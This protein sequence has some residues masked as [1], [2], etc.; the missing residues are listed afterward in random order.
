[1]QTKPDAQAKLKERL[2]QL[3]RG[4]LLVEKDASDES[5]IFQCIAAKDLNGLKELIKSGNFENETSFG[6][7]I[8]RVTACIGSVEIMDFLCNHPKIKN[9]KQDRFETFLIAAYE[10]RLDM[11]QYFIQHGMNDK[12]RVKCSSGTTALIEA[13]KNG[14]FEMVKF[15]IN[16]QSDVNAT[17]DSRKTAL[18][19]AVMNSHIDIALYLIP[20]MK[21]LN[22][23]EKNGFSVLIFT[24]FVGAEPDLASNSLV[25]RKAISK[26]SFSED[27]ADKENQILRDMKHRRALIKSRTELNFSEMCSNEK[28]YSI[29]EQEIQRSHAFLK[30]AQLLIQCKV[31]VNYIDEYGR[32]ALIYATINNQ[33]EIVELLLKNDATKLID[34]VGKDSATAL[35]RAIV[36][37][38]FNIVRLLLDHGADIN[39]ESKNKVGLHPFLNIPAHYNSE[40]YQLLIER[41]ADVNFLNETRPFLIGMIR[42]NE[43]KIALLMVQN[44]IDI[45]ETC[46]SGETPLQIACDYSEQNL[47]S[48]K[49]SDSAQNQLRLVEDLINAL[50]TRG[51]QVNTR[52]AS[53]ASPLH[54]CAMLGLRTAVNNLLI[55]GADATAKDNFNQEPII[56]AICNG[57][58]EI[59]KFLYEKRSKQLDEVRLLLYAAQNNQIEICQYLLSRKID[60]NGVG[61]LDISKDSKIQTLITHPLSAAAASGN[62]VLVQLFI[63]AGASV[64]VAGNDGHNP[65][66]M[67]VIQGDNES[68]K[69]LIEALLVETK[70]SSINLMEV[71]RKIQHAVNYAITYEKI[72]QFLLLTKGLFDLFPESRNQ[73]MVE[74]FFAA[75][76]ANSKNILKYFFESKE[77]NETFILNLNVAIIRA[78]ENN[79]DKLFRNLFEISKFD[80][81][82][83]IEGLSLLKLAVLKD[84][85]T[86]VEEILKLKADPHFLGSDQQSALQFALMNKK[87]K[88]GIL[89]LEKRILSGLSEFFIKN[90]KVEDRK[91]FRNLLKLFCE[92][93]CAD[94]KPYCEMADKTEGLRLFVFDKYHY[95]SFSVLIEVFKTVYGLEQ[96]HSL[97]REDLELHLLAVKYGSDSAEVKLAKDTQ[98]LTSGLLLEST[99]NEFQRNAY[100]QSVEESIGYINVLIEKIRVEIKICYDF[101]S[102]EAG[103]EK[104]GTDVWV[105][106]SNKYEKMN[107]DVDNLA[108]K[109]LSAEEDIIKYKE[110]YIVLAC[111]FEE[112]IKAMLKLKDWEGAQKEK[113]AFDTDIQLKAWLMDARSHIVSFNDFSE[114]L[115]K[116]HEDLQADQKRNQQMRETYLKSNKNKKPKA[117][118]EMQAQRSQLSDKTHLQKKLNKAS[119]SEVSRNQRMSDL[120]NKKARQVA[121][122]QKRQLELKLEKDRKRDFDTEETSDLTVTSYQ[123]YS[124]RAALKPKPYTLNIAGGFYLQLGLKDEMAVVA[125]IT[126]FCKNLGTIEYNKRFQIMTAAKNAFLG[127]G[128]RMMEIILQE[129]GVPNFTVEEAAKFRNFLYHAKSELFELWSLDDVQKMICDLCFYLDGCLRKNEANGEVSAVQ[130]K[131]SACFKTMMELSVFEY[132]LDICVREWE[133]NQN[134]EIYY[135]QAGDIPEILLDHARKFTLGRS[136]AFAAEIRKLSPNHYEARKTLYDLY[137]LPYVEYEQLI[138]L[139]KIARHVKSNPFVPNVALLD[140]MKFRKPLGPAE[141]TLQSAPVLAASTQD[142]MPLTVASSSTSVP[143]VSSAVSGPQVTAVTPM[144]NVHQ[145]LQSAENSRLRPVS[146]LGD[147]KAVDRKKADKQKV[148]G[149]KS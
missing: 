104:F 140:G 121:F 91:L 30:V 138:E 98:A 35:N 42:R 127:L 76:E 24:T 130:I 125:M 45:D 83:E 107:T 77:F 9:R 102:S 99:I 143:P 23:T 1:M 105:R 84:N 92:K 110:D 10:G 36:D 60:V 114:T 144:F 55:A 78:L 74:M 2:K 17:N 65:L 111:Q 117:S 124:S 48:Q 96:S 108:E 80:P 94:F 40:L 63:N 54:I 136:G 4:K 142:A 5:P 118:S 100:G 86:M 132:S 53:G 90:V 103:I 115:T 59:T 75:C 34:Q 70:N 58:L 145:A 11:V 50:I 37:G 12:L 120:A 44:G 27:K 135:Q 18:M 112:K 137:R 56:Y 113:V 43:L 57:Q 46:V 88:S 66:S 139:G 68:L 25:A 8:L 133:A 134:N 72:D 22:L 26:G 3:A 15:L 14:Q 38:Y 41:K 16:N 21:D 73:L 129:G 123:R 101:L 61:K 85:C 82:R 97:N 32:T 95:F 79:N 128:A 31:N 6:M 109:L 87:T 126:A 47:K 39:I 106:I 148:Q 119:E 116:Y 69:L 13:A 19:C 147:N 149:K 28:K 141:E 71:K 81:K 52:N 33:Y 20:L 29:E 122:W 146:D 93:I 89:L 67:C 7:S 64:N 62:P 131:N 51:S 49:F